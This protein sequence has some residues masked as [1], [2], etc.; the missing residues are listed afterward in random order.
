MLRG[1]PLKGP[2]IG[3]GLRGCRWLAADVRAKPVASAES[4]CNS[5]LFQT[6]FQQSAFVFRRDDVPGSGNWEL[7]N[8][9]GESGVDRYAPGQRCAAYWCA[10]RTPS[11]PSF[12]TRA[13]LRAGHPRPSYRGASAAQQRNVVGRSRST[14]WAPSRCVCPA[15]SSSSRRSRRAST[16][17]V[18]HVSLL[19]VAAAATIT[20]IIAQDSCVVSA[21]NRFGGPLRAMRRRVGMPQCP[22]PPARPV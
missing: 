1:A 11:L 21:A 15:P 10:T 20:T 2:P 14:S 13:L 17:R 3:K 6:V 16:M 4:G 22:G 12:R 7:A 18:R 19:L 8:Q 5:T 9:R